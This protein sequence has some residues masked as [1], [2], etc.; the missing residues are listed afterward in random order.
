MSE[1]M[2][3]S[4]QQHERRHRICLHT[5]GSPFTKNVKRS[6]LAKLPYDGL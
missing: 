4:V 5:L 1:D 2:E 3:I 6:V